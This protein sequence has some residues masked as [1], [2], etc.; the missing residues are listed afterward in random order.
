MKHSS[1]IIA[2]LVI[3]AGI[4]FGLFYDTPVDLK[5]DDI[6]IE[7]KYT[8]SQLVVERP[9]LRSPKATADITIHTKM[10]SWLDVVTVFYDS[11]GDRV[12]RAVAEIKHHVSVG[13]TT[14]VP[15][16]FDD[17]S[18]LRNAASVRVEVIPISPLELLERFVDTAKE[19]EQ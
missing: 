1:V 8:I 11:D 15:L 4:Y 5:F 14:T 10:D 6:E 17:G 16:N 9:L 13:Q 18:R 12:G 19:M 2:L 7:N 3:A